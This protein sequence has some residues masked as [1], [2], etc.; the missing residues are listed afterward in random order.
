MIDPKQKAKKEWYK[1]IGN[2][3]LPVKNKPFIGKD[4]LF[5]VSVGKYV[6]IAL[7]KQ[8]LIEKKNRFKIINKIEKFSGKTDNVM[9]FSKD[10]F[11]LLKKKYGNI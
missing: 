6:D 9:M 11:E 2:F 3:L 10:N 1:D 4:D 8:R 7:K 5:E